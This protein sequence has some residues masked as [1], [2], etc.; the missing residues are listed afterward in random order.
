MYEFW[1]VHQAS[2]LANKI[3]NFKS[4]Q[5]KNPMHTPLTVDLSQ[6][7]TGC[8]E[9]FPV[10]LEDTLMELCAAEISER[11]IGYSQRQERLASEKTYESSE[12]DVKT[13]PAWRHLTKH[14]TSTHLTK[15]RQSTTASLSA[16]HE[17]VFWTWLH[18][19]PWSR[20]R[21]FIYAHGSS[22]SAHGRSPAIGRCTFRPEEVSSKKRLLNDSPHLNAELYRGTPPW[23]VAY[24]LM[25]VHYLEEKR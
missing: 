16:A 13:F 19:S 1:R 15:K 21:G 2:S 11:S 8:Q 9:W 20:G 5:Q 6:Q 25:H 3:P 24:P 18:Y 4:L 10:P 17:R 22:P 23:F 7:Q 14:V 12:H